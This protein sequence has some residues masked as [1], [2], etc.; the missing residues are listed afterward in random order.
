LL[1]G[2]HRRQKT[3]SFAQ[4]GQIYFG[5]V[6][7]FCIGVDT[8]WLDSRIPWLGLHEKGGTVSGN[9]LIPLLPGRIDPSR[10]KAGID[11]LMRPG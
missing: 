1:L 6:G 2:P 7:Q 3:V 11:S 5:G 4:V 9:L 8:L 10:F